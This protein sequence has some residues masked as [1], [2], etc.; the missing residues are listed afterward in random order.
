[1]KSNSLEI[2]TD[3]NL[4]YEETLLP[5]NPWMTRVRTDWQKHEKVNFTDKQMTRK[6][7]GKNSKRKHS[8][9]WN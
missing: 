2:Y 3:K 6:Q 7:K 9:Q 1:M 4:I 8:R 5:G